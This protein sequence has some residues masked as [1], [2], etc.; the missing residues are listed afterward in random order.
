M[1]ARLT[2][3]RYVLHNIILYYSRATF[4]G[5]RLRVVLRCGRATFA[6]LRSRLRL[7]VRVRVR[8]PQ[9]LWATTRGT[10]HN[11]LATDLWAFTGQRGVLH[12][13]ERYGAHNL[14]GTEAKTIELR[15]IPVHIHREVLGNQV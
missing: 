13:S 8:K 2:R 11:A 10:G 3:S 5:L 6:G 12:G 4:A 9:V 15:E 14:L 7:R 1:A